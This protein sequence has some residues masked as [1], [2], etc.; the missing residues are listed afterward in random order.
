MAQTLGGL[1]FEVSGPGQDTQHIF[2]S[3]GLR[4]VIC[5]SGGAGASDIVMKSLMYSI[6]SYLIIITS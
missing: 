2:L 6:W 4:L 1:K 5:V 3:S